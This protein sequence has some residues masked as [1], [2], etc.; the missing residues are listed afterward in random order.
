MIPAS[1]ER[2]R[3]RA[4]WLLV[5]SAALGATSLVLGSTVAAIAARDMLDVP[6]LVGT[7]SAAVV[8]GVATGTSLLAAV[9]VRLGQRAGL[10]LGYAIG[11]AGG[12]SA[13]WGVGADA[14]AALLVGLFLLGFAN[15]S[16]ALSRYAS[17]E[18]AAPERRASAISLVVWANTI[19]AV[20]GPT[21]APV[22]ASFV[23]ES[24]GVATEGPLLVAGLLALVAATLL[25]LLLRPD[26]RDLAVADATSQVLD[27]ATAAGGHR[28][29]MR[30]I[31][32][33]PPVATALTAMI[34]GQVVMVVI[35]SMTPVH[36]TEHG[37]DLG[38]V[39]V[40]LSAHM[41]GMFVLSPL[42][43]RIADRFGP[44][45][46]I[47]ASIVTLTVAATM[48]ALAP[49]DGGVVLLVA[50]FVLGYGWN[51][52]FVAGSSLL[53]SGLEASER[54]RAQGFSDTLVW[55]SSA[56][57]S[58]GAGVVLAAV[59]FAALGVAGVALLALAT[60]ALWRLRGELSPVRAT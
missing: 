43:G 27:T 7:A 25:P 10:T 2:A 54:T 9:I 33:R 11:A 1:L 47:A 42:S 18:M 52:G 14:F 35:M 36:M 20:L 49:A 32:R 41:L 12:L 46:T 5:A 4:S 21:L 53:T 34:V 48:A 29:R 45:A 23:E 50:L 15:S 22:A 31:V 28:S 58:L 56:L 39:G 13:A 24:G 8:I 19:G 30:D 26:V 55:G 60:I 44:P 57:A 40:V 16:A 17:A 3:R 6:A 51:L 38:A 37:H 59:G